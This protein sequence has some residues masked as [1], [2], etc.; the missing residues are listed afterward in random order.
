MVHAAGQRE[1]AFQRIG[2]VELD[3]FR[4]HAGVKGGH[5]HLG[6]IDGGK[7]VHGHARQADYA[8]GH[9]READ[10]DDEVRI[11][12]GEA[13]HGRLILAFVVQKVDRFGPHRLAGLQSAAIADYH[14][15]AVRHARQRFRVAGIL[16]AQRHGPLLNLVGRVHH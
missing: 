14:L 15:L 3:V 9:E 12:N 1:E 11:A 10:D 7:Q 5:H 16:N 4:R 8:N 13:R 2:D 6:N